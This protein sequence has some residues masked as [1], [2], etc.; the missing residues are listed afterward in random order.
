MPGSLRHILALG[1]VLAL[2]GCVS[3][4]TGYHEPA[5]SKAPAPRIVFDGLALDPA[6]EE[7]I[8]ALD[9]HRISDADVRTTLA[10]GPTP[11]I[12]NLHGGIYPVHL[13]MESF[14]RF[15][16]RMGYPEAKIRDP[17]SGELSHSPYEDSRQLAGSIAWY[18]ERE[19]VRPLLIGHSQGGMQAVKVLYDYAGAFGTSL[20]VWNP[21]TGQAEN[22]TTIVDPLTGMQRPLVGLVLPYASAVGAGGAAALL[23]NQWSMARRLHV[24][25]DSVEDFTG[26]FLGLDLIAWDLPGMR[27]ERYRTAGTAHVRNVRLPSEYSHVF[28]P[29]T[30]HLGREPKYRD[31]INAWQPAFAAN[32][33]PQPDGATNILWAADVWF[34]VKKHWTL[35][36][37]R[38]IS[39]RRM[40]SAGIPRPVAR[41]E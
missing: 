34:S 9:A 7:R 29:D 15:L 33:P 37:Q 20:A 32:P 38:L 25:P 2:A 35:E 27:D 12:V 3:A 28:V 26:Y 31:W 41:T 23:P 30:A 13:L 21:L 40:A 1:A 5:Y 18:Y 17:G 16:M 39:A 24:I 14:A 6:L 11:R 4:P 10:K 36:A 8:L 22:R 19:G